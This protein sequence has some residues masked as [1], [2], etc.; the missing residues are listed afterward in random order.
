M[1]A[2]KK[3]IKDQIVKDWMQEFPNKN[4]RQGYLAAIRK[5]KKNLHIKSLD[6]HLKQTPHATEDIKRFLISLEGK[7]SKTKA[8]YVAAVKSFFVDHNVPFDETAWRKLRRRGIMP[9][10]VMAE[11]RDKKPTKT[12]LKK[13][14]NYLDVK[15]RAQVLFL[16]SSGARVGESLLLLEEDFDLEADPP[17]AQIRSVYTK[18][19]VGARIVYYSYEARDAIKDWLNIKDTLKKRN[20]KK[21][22]DNRVFGWGVYTARDMWNRAI[23]KANLDEKDE[24]TKRRLYHIHSLRKYF[25][26]K[27]GL[28]L[29]TTNA[30]MGHVEYLDASYVRQN[31]SEIAEAYLEAMPNVSVYQVETPEIKNL[32]QE[33]EELK[34]RLQRM[35]SKVSKLDNIEKMYDEIVAMRDFLKDSLNGKNT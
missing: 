16:S 28:D 12:Q 26:T 29:D 11:T 23:R 17:K 31:Q 34:D 9:K 25:R 13:I 15:G 1:V 20:G 8:A 6:E 22:R 4:T 18:G 24:V 32:E 14:L 33:N 27:I 3:E 5:F 10:R 35:E 2:P 30:L 7:P 19:G 21:Y